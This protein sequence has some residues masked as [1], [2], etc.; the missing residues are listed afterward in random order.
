MKDMKL[1][2][3]IAWK[4]YKKSN[5][6][7]DELFGEAQL[8]YS[9]ALKAYD[10]SNGAKF[11]TYAYTRI[12]N[13]LIDFCKQETRKQSH[14]VSIDEHEIE[15]QDILSESLMDIVKEWPEDCQTIVNTVIEQFDYID[16]GAA[17][18]KQS[19]PIGSSKKDR[20]MRQLKKQGWRSFKI[21]K[22][23]NRVENFLKNH[24]EIV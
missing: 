23:M 10:E 1:I 3:S 11:T 13:R 21:Q 8:A 24:A 19:K 4:Y 12:K 18:Y 2:Y 15:L 22:N 6:D 5:I 14:L 20:L 7:F 9:E 16:G 17:E